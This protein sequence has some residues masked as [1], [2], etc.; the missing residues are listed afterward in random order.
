MALA[1]V[2][3]LGLVSCS[4]GQYWNEPADKGDIVAFAK[5]AATISLQPSES[6][7]ESY[8]VTVSRSDNRGELQV[9]VTLTTKYPD[10]LSG[11]ESV[12]FANGSFT[13]DYVISIGDVEP[14]VAYSATLAVQQ[15]Q[16]GALTHP[17]SKNLTF[18]LNLTQVLSWSVLTEHAIYYDNIVADLYGAS[19]F[20][21]YPAEVTVVKCDNFD[22]L[23]RIL[24]PFKDFNEYGLA[25]QN[26]GYIEIDA[27][28][29][30]H[31]FVPTS[32][33]GILDGGEALI[34]IMTISNYFMDKGT[35]ASDMPEVFWGKFA[36]N[37]FTF[38]A[39]AGAAS[40]GMFIAY[41]GGQ[42][43]YICDVDFT[44]DLAPAAEK[45]AK[46]TVKSGKATMSSPFVIDASKARLN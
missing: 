12:T 36:D 45:P 15:P 4:E 30:E 42:G 5:P 46:I 21:N 29:P 18:T 22:G 26:G 17:D 31:I 13:A 10:V 33:T 43:P 34:E 6:A 9:P 8:T 11:P 39:F 44:L 27:R 25:V 28:D 14:G 23:Y 38:S 32:P 16:E 41:I 19:D 20:A 35:P 2:A 40:N 7:P 37:K 24:E 1:A 3:V